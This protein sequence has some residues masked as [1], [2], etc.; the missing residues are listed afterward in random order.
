MTSKADD[1][2]DKLSVFIMEQ[3]KSTGDSSDGVTIS[4]SDAASC[5]TRNGTSISLYH[6]TRTKA[7]DNQSKQLKK[8]QLKI[9]DKIVQPLASLHNIAENGTL[10]KGECI[11]LIE[12]LS[13]QVG[14]RHNGL[15]TTKLINKLDTTESGVLNAKQL[16]QLVYQLVYSQLVKNEQLL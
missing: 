7:K 8:Y 1:D 14:I 5:S 13:K 10:E 9:I 3:V 4:N 15:S 11:S 12:R 2:F 6:S 16:S